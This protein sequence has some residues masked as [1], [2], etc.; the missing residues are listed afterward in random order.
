VIKRVIPDTLLGRA[1][2]VLLFGVVISHLAGL[3]IYLTD[4]SHLLTLWGGHKMA[5]EIAAI[6]RIVD[7]RGWHRAPMGAHSLAKTRPQVGVEPSAA[8]EQ[9]RRGLAS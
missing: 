5:A 2:A 4:R 6:T 3:L 9:V 1:L 8:G 7:S